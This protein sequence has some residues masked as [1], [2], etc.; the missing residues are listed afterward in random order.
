MEGVELAAGRP[1][2]DLQ[3]LGL[4]ASQNAKEDSAAGAELTPAWGLLLCHLL[5]P[6][7]GTSATRT[8]F[9]LAGVNYFMSNL[10]PP[11]LGSC[12]PG[13]HTFLPTALPGPAFPFSSP[14]LESKQLCLMPS[15]QGI[16]SWATFLWWLRLIVPVSSSIP[17]VP[18]QGSGCG[19]PSLLMQH[20][21]MVS[22]QA[23][24]ALQH[25]RHA[26]AESD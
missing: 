11:L 25:N 5:A 10:C 1:Y 20:P 6:A 14:S 3:S 7:P 16:F 23:W 2:G 15:L 19:C 21:L 4:S 9:F 18:S 26:A 13:A 12:C 17:G 24:E 8:P 22:T